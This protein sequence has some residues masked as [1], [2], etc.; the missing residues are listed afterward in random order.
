MSMPDE[1]PAAVTT[2]PCTTTRLSVGFAPSS[3]SCSCAAQ[4]VVAS[5]PRRMPAAPSSREPVHTDVVHWLVSCAARSQSSSGFGVISTRVPK[6]PGTM[7]MSGC[8]TADSGSSATSVSCRLSVRYGP[9]V[10]ATQR[11]RAPGRRESTSYGPMASS[12]VMRSNSGMAMSMG[13]PLVPHSAIAGGYTP[14][15]GLC[16]FCWPG[17]HDKEARRMIKPYTAVGLIPTVRGIRKRKDIKLNL[18]HLHHLVKA[19]SWLSS[20]DL[21]V[22]LIAF[23]EGALQA[24]NDEVLDLDHAQFARECAIDIPGEETEALGKIAKEYN[25]FVMAQAKARHP[26]LKDRF[27]NVGFIINPRGKVILQHYK[28][29]P[30]FPVE[31]SVCPHDVYDWWVAKYGRTLN[32]FWPVADTEIGRLGIMMANEGSYP[33]NARALALNGA[34]VV[35]RASYPHPAT[36]NE[37]FEIQSRA[38]ALDN[39]MY[40]VAPNMGT[41]YLFPEETTPIDTFGGRSFVIDY[42]GR[43]VGR[44][45][46]GAGST[47]VGGVIDIEALRDHRA[48]AQ[49]DNWMKDLRTELYQIVYDKPISPKNLYLKGR[50]AHT[51]FGLFAESHHFQ[52]AEGARRGLNPLVAGFGPAL[53]DRAVLDALASLHGMSLAEAIRANLPGIDPAHFL[54]EFAAFDVTPFPP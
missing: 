44:Q 20:L 25:A 37:I 54:P 35:Y 9:G 52:I 11:M 24:F 31:H 51:A 23:P 5:S 39:N 13:F 41:Y 3:A 21:P 14:A 26:D 19:A 47:Y 50:I 17:S 27:F 28:V 29:S 40:V 53:L 48:R 12:A 46:Y 1:T 6:P 32:A 18:E 2:L 45:D 34:E 30:L 38:R 15:G 10:T 7:M 49:W 22:R 33:E 43:I 4:C 16:Y 42:K 36:G 8:G